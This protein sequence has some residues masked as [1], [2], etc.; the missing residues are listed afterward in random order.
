MNELERFIAVLGMATLIMAGL[1]L[2]YLGPNRRRLIAITSVYRP[3]SLGLLMLHCLSTIVVAVLHL[4]SSAVPPL[5]LAWALA[6]LAFCVLRCWRSTMPIAL[7]F[8]GSPCSSAALG[9]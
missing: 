4:P 2:P 1:L 3:I 8:G 5:A 6:L 7:N 9:R